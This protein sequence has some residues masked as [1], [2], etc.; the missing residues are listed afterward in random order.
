MKFKKPRRIK[1][2]PNYQP[3]TVEFRKSHKGII[4][5]IQFFQRGEFPQ[6][7]MHKTAYLITKEQVAAWLFA[8]NNPDLDIYN[9]ELIKNAPGKTEGAP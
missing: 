1:P 7:V 6:F 3:W 4:A 9:G 5:D 8:L 2:S